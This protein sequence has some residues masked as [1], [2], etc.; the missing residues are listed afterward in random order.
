ML[1]AEVEPPLIG[2][3]LRYTG[4][5]QSRAASMLGITRNTLR[6]KMQRYSITAQSSRITRLR[7]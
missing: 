3:V 6:T 1:L 7:R 5:N 2:E 4:G